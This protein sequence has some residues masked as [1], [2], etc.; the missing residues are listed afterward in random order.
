MRMG[1]G[2]ESVCV[3][4]AYVFA[5]HIQID[6]RGTDP[7]AEKQCWLGTCGEQRRLGLSR[8]QHYLFFGLADAPVPRAPGMS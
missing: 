7:T 6:K 8:E 1:Q 5:S 2:V 4:T 3:P